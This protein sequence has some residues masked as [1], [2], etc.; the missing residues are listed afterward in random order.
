MNDEKSVQSY[1]KKD[2]ER[3]SDF[4]STD[5][6]IF[7]H[8]I[9]KR[10]MWKIYK[11]SINQIY[12]HIDKTT[13]ILDAGC[14]IGHFLFELNKIEDLNRIIGLDFL[15]EPLVI[16]KKNSRFFNK[17]SFFECD[18]QSLC[19]KNKS[20]DIIYC[21]NT[22]H[23]LSKDKLKKTLLEFS[24]VCSKLLVLEIRNKDFLFNSFF[25]SILLSSKYR[26]LPQYYTS[27]NWI[28]NFFRKQGFLLKHTMGKFSYNCFC[29]RIVLIFEKDVR[30]I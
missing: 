10:H 15:R 14:G 13:S 27:I 5:E 17:A 9:C 22:L 6:K 16:A 24:R 20:I 21:L 8:F 2:C 28:E 18:F 29:R 25:N 19:F 12:T 4:Y 26:I 7:Y 23:H 3:K 1:F 11:K 30:I